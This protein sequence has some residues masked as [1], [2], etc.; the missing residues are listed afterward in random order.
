M[1]LNVFWNDSL[2]WNLSMQSIPSEENAEVLIHPTAS[3]ISRDCRCSIGLSLKDR[4]PKKRLWYMLALVE[5]G[6]TTNAERRVNSPIR[7][8]LVSTFARKVMLL[9]E[10]QT[11]KIKGTAS[12]GQYTFA[13]R[14]V[15]S[16]N[17]DTMLHN[18]LILVG[19]WRKIRNDAI[20]RKR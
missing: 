13:G 1:T 2:L 3:S 18:R 9:F 8:K 4:T 15:A 20:M 7:L 16:K 10:N 6:F 17:T 14:E 12:S 11:D 19:Y 5:L